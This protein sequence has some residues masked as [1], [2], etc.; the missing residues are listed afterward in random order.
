RHA[1]ARAMVRAGPRSPRPR[2]GVRVSAA[3]TTDLPV[4]EE[5]A[6]TA[7]IMGSGVERVYDVGV[8]GLHRLLDHRDKLLKARAIVVVAGMEGARP[9]AVA[10]RGGVLVGGDP[11]GRG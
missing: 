2:P 5:A 1:A 6:S 3:G 11:P 7:E 9:G 4:A 10:G 8:A